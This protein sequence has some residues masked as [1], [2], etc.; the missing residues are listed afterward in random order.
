MLILP[1]YFFSDMDTNG[2][3]SNV[4]RAALCTLISVSKASDLLTGGSTSSAS[5]SWQAALSIPECQGAD[6]LMNIP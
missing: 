2:A 6:V 3:G 1:I 5:L 4:E